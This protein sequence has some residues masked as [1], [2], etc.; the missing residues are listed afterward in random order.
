MKLE[1]PASRFE[2]L[3]TSD[4]WQ[5]PIFGLLKTQL[6]KVIKKLKETGLRLVYIYTRH[7]SNELRFVYC[8]FGKY[9][10]MVACLSWCLAC[11]VP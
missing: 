3:L 7:P 2:V 11:G 4:F 10:T 8:S 9:G 5:Y 1:K 6:E